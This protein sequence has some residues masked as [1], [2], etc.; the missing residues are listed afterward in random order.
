MHWYRLCKRLSWRQ[1]GIKSVL[2]F[3]QFNGLDNIMGEMSLKE[4]MSL[5]KRTERTKFKGQILNPLIKADLVE[6][7]I[8]DK[9]TSLKQKYRLK[10]DT[11]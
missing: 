8:P 5:L 3:D 10:R 7:T 1:V 9:P 6:P 11:H 2:N 4:L